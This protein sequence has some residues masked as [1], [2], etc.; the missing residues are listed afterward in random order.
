MSHEIKIHEVQTVILRELLF[1]PQASYSD[2]QRPT[3]LTSDHFNFH[4]NRLMEVGFVERPKRGVYKLS[5]AGKEYANKL[6]TD[7]NTIERQPK[8][9]VMLAITKDFDSAQKFI[10]QKRVKNP[11]YGFY[12]FPTGKV[13]WGETIIE[14][15]K[16]E[17]MEETGL[18]A[19][20]EIAGAYHE[21]V[22]LAE[23]DELMEDKIFFICRASNIRGK[24]QEKFEGGENQWLTIEEF[25][26]KDK[27]FSSI[28]DELKIMTTNTWLLE[29]STQYKSD[30]F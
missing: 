29:R 17:C 19:D 12:G 16:R 14:T 9:A 20:F 30:I 4:I 24:L 10:I 27:K 26:Q 18:E 6:D 11:N 1:R 13:R 28:D 2:L 8:V 22:R 15:A 7:S 23:T 5:L 21:H 25:R 3:G